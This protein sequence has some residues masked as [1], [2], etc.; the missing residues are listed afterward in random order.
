MTLV[1]FTVS[2]GPSNMVLATKQLEVV[3]R[4]NERIVFSDGRKFCAY[5]VTHHFGNHGDIIEV[6][7]I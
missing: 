4:E 6:Q 2:T 5:R 3:P 1:N 7:L